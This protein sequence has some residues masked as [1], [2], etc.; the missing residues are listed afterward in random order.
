MSSYSSDSEESVYSE[1]GALWEGDEEVEVVAPTVDQASSG[2]IE[3]D[4]AASATSDK[5][6]TAINS[7]DAESTASD[8]PE[9]PSF[10]PA[11]DAEIRGESF[12]FLSPE[13]IDILVSL[14]TPRTKSYHDKQTVQHSGGILFVLRGE[15]SVVETHRIGSIATLIAGETHGQIELLLQGTRG[16]SPTRLSSSR[17]STLCASL[18]QAEIEANLP[19]LP[20]LL[21]LNK[22][23]WLR[24]LP[25]DDRAY[26]A[27]GLSP[28][29]YE[30]GQYLVRQGAPVDGLSMII[31]GTCKVTQK[32]GQ[33]E[34]PVSPKIVNM[35]GLG[36]VS[37]KV[38]THLYTGHF[39]GEMS[40]VAE[41]IVKGKID[42]NASVVADTEI[43]ATAVF[44]ANQSKVLLSRSAEF[45]EAL[46]QEVKRK[47][48]IQKRR[49]TGSQLDKIGGLVRSASMQR[50]TE[51]QHLKSKKKVRH[52][53]IVVRSRT[54]TNEPEHN[55]KTA[56]KEADAPSK[57]TKNVS[58]RNVTIINGFVVLETL[59]KGS[60][61]KVKLV[62]KGGKYFAM[63][64]ISRSILKRMK[65][66]VTGQSI[67]DHEQEV[68]TMMMEV[69][70]MKRMHHV[71]VI[72]LE[73]VL[74]DPNHEQLYIISEYCAGG[75]VMQKAQKSAQSKDGGRR[76][77]GQPLPRK[78]AHRYT[79]DLVRGIAYCH[80]QGI[81]HR[82]IKP[83]N[84][85]K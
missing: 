82:D 84:L 25:H 35:L 42:A 63:K 70:L 22:C 83:E 53:T 75:E 49:K 24:D 74:D 16:I 65:R 30:M 13:S 6:D 67:A 9:A 33:E 44:P 73:E 29:V 40:L 64:I 69:A 60:F 79:R 8:D 78:L 37:T 43:V 10:A 46:V 47:E 72:G 51:H 76:L 41:A 17:D 2:Q 5:T 71:N 85:C 27:A 14:L 62:E 80:S 3:Q 4:A 58:K 56:E 39:F 1:A 77:V 68:S 55:T 23:S 15:V 19:L 12:R 34:G 28:R 52:S 36:D 31:R 48:A 32:I 26:I 11:V 21:V 81:V 45:R 18:S 38:V 59:G 20:G 66:R 57:K 50:V 61:G 54:K 7:T